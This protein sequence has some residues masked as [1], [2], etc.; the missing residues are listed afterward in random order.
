MREGKIYQSLSGFYDVYSDGKI[1]RTRARGNFR[2]LQIKPLVGDKVKFDITN[3]NEGY[4]L[5]IMPRFNVLVRPPISNTNQAIVV[6]SAVQPDFSTRLL[7]KELVALE[8]EKIV[9]LIYF[10]KTDLLDEG[11]LINFKKIASDYEQKVG[12]KVILPST[13]GHQLKKI[14]ESLKGKQTVVLGQTGAGKSTLLNKIDSNLNLK[15]G[16]VSKA[17]SRGKHTTRKVSLL[18]INDGLVADTPGFSTFDAND[19]K[20]NELKNYYPDFEKVADNCKFR[21]CLHIN[22]PGCAVKMGVKNGTILASRYENYLKQYE[23]VKNQK[24]IYNK[25]RGK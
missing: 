19:L 17:L 6:V 20:A 21:E 24:P 23:V 12:Y 14:F 7:D 9:P 2:K 1:F 18:N 10:T 13:D 25:K 4:I 15:T 5:E 11:Q 8:Q 3:E 16:E 22:E